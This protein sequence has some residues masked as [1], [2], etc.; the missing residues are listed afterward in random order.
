MFAWGNLKYWLIF[1]KANFLAFAAMDCVES[2][3]DVVTVYKLS[4][5]TK[6]LKMKPFHNPQHPKIAIENADD[7]LSF[8][9]F[10]N[11]YDLEPADLATEVSQGMN[12]WVD[13]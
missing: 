2:E 9:Y 13:C 6:D 12:V 8:V 4:S 3:C 11:S 5:G 1:T 7:T 10:E